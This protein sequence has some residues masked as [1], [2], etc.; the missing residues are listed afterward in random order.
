MRI[1]KSQETN[2]DTICCIVAH[3][4]NQFLQYL[5][6]DDSAGADK[7]DGQDKGKK[8]KAMQSTNL[9]PQSDLPSLTDFAL[10]KDLV[11]KILQDK[12]LDPNNRNN[13]FFQHK[14]MTPK[15]AEETP[16][17][18]LSVEVGLLIEILTTKLQN[19]EEKKHSNVEDMINQKI[20]GL[21]FSM[22]RKVSDQYE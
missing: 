3:M 18:R 5:Q 9:G 21:V 4:M 15:E 17:L 20:L 6:V 13:I 22:M 11:E 8:G 1:M 14:G 7:G 2:I 19:I 10:V 16:S 12:I